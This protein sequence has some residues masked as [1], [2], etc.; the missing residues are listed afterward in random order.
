MHKLILGLFT[1][2]TAMS[3]WA[4]SPCSSVTIKGNE[5]W[6]DGKRI[7]R[8]DRG[9]TAPRWSPSREQLAYVN[10]FE[11]STDPVS[12]IVIVDRTGRVQETIPIPEDAMFNAVLAMGWRNPA[13]IWIDGHVNPSSGIYEEFDLTTREMKNETLGAFFS[14]SPNGDVLA[15]R[16]QEAHPPNPKYHAPLMLNDTTVNMPSNVVIMGPLVWSPAGD[17]LAVGLHE[18]ERAGVAFVTARG[19]IERVQSLPLTGRPYALEWEDDNGVL[20]RPGHAAQTYRVTRTGKVEDAKKTIAIQTT[21]N[22]CRA[23]STQ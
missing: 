8:D 17:R 18:D 13:T 6:V 16:A 2:T 23:L 14:W 10:N 5:L 12:H 11:L 1:I 3:A 21:D 4:A 15:Y 20:V 19:V 22:P 9:I 7:L